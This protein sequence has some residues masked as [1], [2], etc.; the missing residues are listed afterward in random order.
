[1]AILRFPSVETAGPEG[2]LAVGGDLEVPSLKLAYESGVFPWPNEDFP[3]LWFAPPLR[4]ILKF[5]ELRVPPRL[6]RELKGKKFHFSV[7]RNFPAVIKACAE[8]ST[9]KS[10]GTWITLRMIEA[11]IRFH[12]AG[13]AHSFE[14]YD[15]KDRLVGGMYGVSIGGMFAGE[16]MFFTESG[17]SKAVLLFAIAYLREQGAQW[18]DIQML[19]PLL[20][21]LGAKEIPRTVFMEKLR[22]A[23]AEK[24]LWP[25]APSESS[26]KRR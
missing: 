15:E 14:C 19:S 1:M 18:M 26:L 2:L 12:R 21:R 7:D 13:Y 20:Q 24:P 22:A 25:S 4:A 5:E 23:L 17:A 6:H 8:G 11:Y 9:R 10:W 3:L 16:S